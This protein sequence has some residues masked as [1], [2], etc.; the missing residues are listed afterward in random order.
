MFRQAVPAERVL[1][2]KDTYVVAN[3]SNALECVSKLRYLYPAPKRPRSFLQKHTHPEKIYHAD[4][5]ISCRRSVRRSSIT[6][7]RPRMFIQLAGA[8]A[9]RAEL[10]MQL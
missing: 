3:F 4:S 10:N 8:D 5:S 1:C 9:D 2:E 7:P 6:A